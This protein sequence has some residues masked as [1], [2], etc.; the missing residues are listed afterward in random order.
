MLGDGAVLG[1][2]HV[3]R[4]TF[5]ALLEHVE[6]RGGAGGGRRLGGVLCNFGGVLCDLTQSDTSDLTGFDPVFLGSTQS[7]ITDLTGFGDVHAAPLSEH[8]LFRHAILSS[9]CRI[10]S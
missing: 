10:P 9:N 6:D 3:K 8:T 7:E 2:G 1:V 5:P 4:I